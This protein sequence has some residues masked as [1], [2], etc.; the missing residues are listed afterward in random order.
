MRITLKSKALIAAMAAA[1]M[2]NLPAMAADLKIGF[3]SDI[4]S[5]DPHVLSGANRNLW[6]HIYE[7]LVEQ[8]ENLRPK[9]AL[10]VSWST[11]DQTTWEFKLRP[12]VTFHNGA[13][14][15]AEDVKYSIDRAINLKGP[16]TFRTYLK[17]IESVNV[18]GPL[19]IRIKTIG[20]QP[21]LADNLSLISIIPKSLGTDVP[22]ESFAKGAT[23]IGTGPYKFG[24][25]E[26]GQ[27]VTFTRNANYWGDK[28]PWENVIF[29]ILP[30]D[31]ARASALLAGTVDLIDGATSKVADSFGQGS[32]FDMA[33]TTSYMLNY[34]QLD[35]FRDNSPY[36]KSNSGAPLPKNP[37]RDLKVRQAIM[38][39]INRDGIIKF[40]MKG[41]GEAANQYVPKTF[42]G[43]DSALKLPPFDLQK[44]KSL[45]AEAGYAD[46]FKM[47][48]HCTNDRYVNDAKMC[49]AVAQSLN[50]IG[51]KVELATMPYSVF[52][53]RATKGDN[54]AS[55]FSFFM[56]GTGA[57]TGD[58][59]QPLSSIS[60]TVDAKSGFGANNYGQYSNKEVDSLIEKA[61]ITLDEKT[62]ADLQKTAAQKA[63][64]DGAI[65]PLIH[66]KAAWAFKKGLTITPRSDG[67]TH[68]MNI[69][70][71]SAK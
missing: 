34:I 28:E 51:L 46:G 62:R 16:R 26:H 15:T 24:T 35:H 59:L 47:T 22:E 3:K 31:P 4:T 49:E 40:L 45:L 39:A 8:D 71:T 1:C 70:E 29:Q 64:V 61:A 18:A 23:A 48:M 65:I 27:R 67:F 36:I 37:L 63:L 54:G 57:V 60:H 2:I 19:T 13:T 14:L 56:V 25:W 7:G 6:A 21:N 41:D 55:E 12:N 5:A 58:S 9:P 68:A 38:H 52:I 50:Q 32:K 17:G 42:F 30:R 43:Y 44:A 66:V 10:A 69:R 33:S 20:P 53:G 11:V